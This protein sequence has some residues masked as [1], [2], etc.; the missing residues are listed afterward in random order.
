MQPPLTN[1]SRQVAI[2]YRYEGDDRDRP[3]NSPKCPPSHCKDVTV[4]MY[5]KDKIVKTK[6]HWDMNQQCF[7]K[8]NNVSVGIILGW[9][10][11]Q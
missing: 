9:S 8:T 3:F 2:M 11:E 6:A 7:V 10:D 1:P 5:R 4:F